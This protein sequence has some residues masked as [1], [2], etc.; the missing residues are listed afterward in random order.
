MSPEARIAALKN[1]PAD[2]WVAFSSD[3]SAV[4]AYGLTYDE[5]VSNAELKGV[6]DPVLVKVPKDWAP[7][8]LQG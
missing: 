1:A 4:I 6:S 7:A 2:G 3:E 8:V 5:A